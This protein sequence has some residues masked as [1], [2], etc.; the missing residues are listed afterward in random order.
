MTSLTRPAPPTSSPAQSKGGA[1][2]ESV[3]VDDLKDFV[4]GAVRLVH[5]A[6]KN[7]GGG[8]GEKK[9]GGGGT[10]GEDTPTAYSNRWVFE[11]RKKKGGKT[12]T[13]CGYT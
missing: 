5:G 12:E 6:A 7:S 8:D 9:G 13:G 1:A 11:Y 2:N 10:A 3:L 4:Q